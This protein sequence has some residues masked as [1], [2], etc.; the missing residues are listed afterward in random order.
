MGP[1]GDW[2]AIIGAGAAIAASLVTAAWV[3]GSKIGRLITAVEGHDT[4][5]KKDR[6]ATER[7]SKD[8]A[9][10][11]SQVECVVHMVDHLE[12]RWVNRQPDDR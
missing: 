2:L 7:N 12:E 11:G 3:L 9:V 8:I 1:D 10:M 4:Q 5:I 6:E